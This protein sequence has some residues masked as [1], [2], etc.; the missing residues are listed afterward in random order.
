[1]AILQVIA[2]LPQKAVHHILVTIALAAGPEVPI[3]LQAKA[4]LAIVEVAADQGHQ[5]LHLEAV[6]QVLV[7]DPQVHPE[8]VEDINIYKR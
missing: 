7:P 1:M 3:L 5:V 2:G 8:V 6:G 4:I